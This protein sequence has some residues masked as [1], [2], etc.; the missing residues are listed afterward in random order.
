MTTAHLT[1]TQITEIRHLHRTGTMGYGQLAKAFGVND[2]TAR[3]IVLGRIRN[4][5]SEVP[6]KPWAETSR[7]YGQGPAQ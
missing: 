4:L 1:D 7:F 6:M 2:T 3:N 5:N